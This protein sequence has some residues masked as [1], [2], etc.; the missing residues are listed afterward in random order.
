MSSRNAGCLVRQRC[1]RVHPTKRCTRVGVSPH[2]LLQQSTRSQCDSQSRRC[3]RE[4]SKPVA[5]SRCRTQGARFELAASRVGA[6]AAHATSSQRH[7]TL[8]GHLKYLSYVF[9]N[10]TPFVV[11]SV[12]YSCSAAAG[13]PVLLVWGS[14]R[15]RG[16]CLRPSSLRRSADG[17]DLRAGM[18]VL[19]TANL[20]A[21]RSGRW[22]RRYNQDGRF[23]MCTL[24]VAQDRQV[25]L[26]PAAPGEGP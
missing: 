13:V 5:A 6:R 25:L 7:A 23:Y 8:C 12:R 15:T 26:F 17:L 14:D 10:K 4:L 1:L 22:L 21:T 19:G 24:R 20:S 11:R 9:L 2:P 16:V 3:V 18:H